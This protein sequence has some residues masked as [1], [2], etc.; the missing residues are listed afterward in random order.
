[1]VGATATASQCVFEP[2]FSPCSDNL[3][4]AGTR[5]GSFRQWAA[6]LRG[7]ACAK[8]GVARLLALHARGWRATLSRAGRL[9]W[10]ERQVPPFRDDGGVVEDSGQDREQQRRILPP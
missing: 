10:D 9:C 7:R 4:G 1:M 5:Q 3:R 8:R 2:G 6:K